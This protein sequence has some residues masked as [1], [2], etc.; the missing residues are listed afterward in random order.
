MSGYT[1]TTIALEPGTA[2]RVS[3]SVYPDERARVS[4]FPPV[5]DTRAFLSVQ[6]GDTGVFI[7]LTSD[8]VVSDTHVRF[9]RELFESAARFLADCERLRDEHADHVEQVDQV[10]DQATPGKAA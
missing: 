6:H 1:Y 7:G 10:P 8:T 3:V 9:A 5:I 4:Y 2:P